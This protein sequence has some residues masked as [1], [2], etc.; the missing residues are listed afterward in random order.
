M[1]HHTAKSNGARMPK[2]VTRRDR[3]SLDVRRGAGG[4]LRARRNG[5]PKCDG[6][7]LLRGD[8]CGTSYSEDVSLWLRICGV[9]DAGTSYDPLGSFYEPDDQRCPVPR[10]P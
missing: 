1:R 7:R 6:S 8:K 5:A 10:I 2:S 9:S 3:V 4:G